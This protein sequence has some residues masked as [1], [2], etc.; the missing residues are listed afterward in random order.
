VYVVKVFE[1]SVQD[2]NGEMDF[3]HL[4]TFPTFPESESS[5]LVLPEHIV[6]PPVT[7]PA[8]VAGETETVNEDEFS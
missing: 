2:E 4:T 6:D 1:I 7:V 8:T 5:A 3:C